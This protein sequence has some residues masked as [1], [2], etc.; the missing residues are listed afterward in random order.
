MSQKYLVRDKVPQQ[1][2]RYKDHHPDWIGSAFAKFLNEEIE[3]I[4]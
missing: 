1:G 4:F 3:D 2:K